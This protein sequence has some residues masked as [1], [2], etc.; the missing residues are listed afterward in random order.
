MTFPSKRSLLTDCLIALI[1]PKVTSVALFCCCYCCWALSF[2]YIYFFYS[3]LGFWCYTVF[4]G[5]M[6]DNLSYTC[7]VLAAC[8]K[9]VTWELPFDIKLPFKLGDLAGTPLWLDVERSVCKVLITAEGRIAGFLLEV[10]GFVL[11]IYGFSTLA[12]YTDLAV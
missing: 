2:L 10:F 9:Q 8:A 7:N 11:T 4:W 5:P 1:V 3:S 12:V 6:N